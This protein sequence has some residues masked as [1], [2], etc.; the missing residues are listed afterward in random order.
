MAWMRALSIVPLLLALATMAAAGE[1]AVSSAADPSTR[2]WTAERYLSARPM[3]PLLRG[4]LVR[5]QPLEGRAASLEGRPAGAAGRGPTLGVPPDPHFYI[6]DRGA[7]PRN[8]RPRA[9]RVPGGQSVGVAGPGPRE[10]RGTA[11]LEFSSSRLVPRDARW[12]YPYSAVGKLFFDKPDGGSG[13]CSASV[14]QR[15][16]LLT[17][18]HCVYTPGEGWHENF[19][20]VPAYFEGNAPFGSWGAR[21]IYTTTEWRNGGNVYPNSGDFGMLL[22]RDNA[23][24]ERLGEVTG[25][26]GWRTNSLTPNHLH[27]LGYPSNLDQGKEMHQVTSGAHDCCFTGTAVY[28]TD[29]RE[30]SS[31]GPWVQNFGVKAKKQNIGKNKKI[32]RV[33]GVYSWLYTSDKKALLAGSSIPKASF[34]SMYRQVCDNDPRNCQE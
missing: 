1:P 16:V 22:M 33:V 26:L 18:G 28:G 6:H 30:G 32:N 23:N 24:G 17:A 34:S 11:G 4:P 3:Q 29:M 19:S 27:I 5:D 31:G 8:L 9:R 25:W 10:N 13:Y 20:Y 14:I 21:R 2:E 15:R 7:H 12:F